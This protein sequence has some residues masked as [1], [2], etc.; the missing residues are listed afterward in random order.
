MLEALEELSP[1]PD[2][3]WDV[4]VDPIDKD[5]EPIYQTES[6]ELDNML[7]IVDNVIDEKKN[8]TIPSRNSRRPPG[9]NVKFSKIS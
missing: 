8:N 5:D 3:A 6:K 4:G 1:E 9:G 7:N 2:E